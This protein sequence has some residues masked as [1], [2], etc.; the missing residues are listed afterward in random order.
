MANMYEVLWVSEK[1]DDFPYVFM[2]KM[3]PTRQKA[4]GVFSLSMDGAK[5]SLLNHEH[6]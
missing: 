3:S 1:M 5:L 4:V 2:E 6:L